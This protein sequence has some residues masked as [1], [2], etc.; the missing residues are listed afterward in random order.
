MPGVISAMAEASGFGGDQKGIEQL[1]KAM[2][3]GEVKSAKVL[4]EF[5]RILAEKSRAGGALEE[6]M[7][8]S[9]AQQARFNNAVTAMIEVMGNNGLEKGFARIFKSMATFLEDNEAGVIALS[10]AFE[11]FSVGVERAL[12]GVSNLADGFEMLARYLG[13]ADEDMALLS[14]TALVLAT[15][16]GRIAAAAGILFLVLEDIAVGMRGGESYTKDLMEFLDENSWVKATAAVGGF[17]LALGAIATAIVGIGSAMGRIPGAGGKGGKGLI[18]SIV[19]TTVGL[20]KRNPKTAAV[21]G[22]LIAFDQVTSAYHKSEDPKIVAER[23]EISLRIRN[24]QRGPGTGVLTEMTNKYPLPGINS[25]MG[26]TTTI[27]KVEIHVDG[28]GD[29]QVVGEVV[30]RKIQELASMSVKN[31]TVTE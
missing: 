6:A 8:T 4:P 17:A 23:E 22:G 28:S 31:L 21:V 1:F 5:A 16:F 30:M 20:V 11:K 18:S 12:Q 2:E 27:D 9:T 13:I 15:R 29:P 14:A 26:N 10:K 7:E 25:P 19:G 3:A 24:L